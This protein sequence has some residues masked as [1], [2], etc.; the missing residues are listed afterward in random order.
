ML[1]KYCD[2][3]K[4]C[5]SEAWSSLLLQVGLVSDY[6]LLAL[7]SV[8]GIT[9]SSDAIT[10]L[11]G[12]RKYPLVLGPYFIGI[13][14]E[15]IWNLLVSVFFR[16]FWHKENWNWLCIATYPSEDES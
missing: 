15:K 14:S 6:D 16:F 13:P 3:S 5:C 10:I 11:F 1:V 8:S 7:D 9:F 4:I 2:I 12:I